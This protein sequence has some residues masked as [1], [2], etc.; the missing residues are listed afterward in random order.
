MI[1]IGTVNGDVIE[2]GGV[3]NV[4][5]HYHYHGDAPAQAP[6]EPDADLKLPARRAEP[7]DT[8]EAEA[9]LDKLSAA[10]IVDECWQPVGLTGEQ[11]G[12]LASEVAGLLHI[13][14]LWQFFGLLW[15]ESPNTL[16]SYFN[17][18]MG[19][20]AGGRF[21]DRLKDALKP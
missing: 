13:R 14:A 5:N 8:P 17:K 7:L 15:D 9:L 10:G 12:L 20:A 18:G 4:T 6:E 11:K 2:N 21:L 1:R 3:K 16:R 19:S